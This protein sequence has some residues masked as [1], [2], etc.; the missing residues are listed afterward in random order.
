MIQH[1]SFLEVTIRFLHKVTVVMYIISYKD[2]GQVIWLYIN[3][4]GY[5]AK[6]TRLNAVI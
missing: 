3:G 2:F 5:I 6:K 4:S 1:T